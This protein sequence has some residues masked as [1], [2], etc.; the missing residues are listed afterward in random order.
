MLDPTLEGIRKL[1]YRSFDELLHEPLPERWIDLI[2][3]LNADENAW[4]KRTRPERINKK[5]H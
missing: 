3:R 2:K 1:W 4:R 5:A